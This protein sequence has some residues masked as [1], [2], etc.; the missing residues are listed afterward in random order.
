MKKFMIIVL[1][2]FGV[3]QMD[4][5]PEVRPQDLG[6]NTG[7]HI[8]EA[9]PE[10]RLPTLE[11]L[12]LMNILGFETGKMKFRQGATYGKSKLMHEGADTFFGHQEIM[13]TLPRKPFGEPIKNRID[14]I[15]RTL[16]QSGYS[17]AFY[18][19]KHE[20]LLIVENALT[21]ADNVECDPG[22]AFNVTAA[23][24]TI[25][26][27]EV[28]K[29]GKL[30]RS[31][32]IV[33]RVITF[34]G[35]GVTID[36]ILSA[37]EEHDGG[38]IGVNAPK[39]GVYNRDYHCIHLGYGVDPEVQIPTI[40]GRAGFPVCLLGKAADVIQN[41]FGKSFSIVETSQVLSRMIEVAKEMDTG[42]ICCNVQETDLAGHQQNVEKYASILQTADALIGK[43][44]ETMQ[45][46][47]LLLVMADHGNDPTIGHPH[48]TRECVPLMIC[49]SEVR[50]CNLGVRSTLSDAGATAAE[51]FGVS[52]P[53]NGRSFLKEITA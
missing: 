21:V 28:L 24:D 52:A 26:F 11:R 46:E 22:Q 4:D 17:T 34:G 18:H 5:V 42:F 29:I 39:S 43:L 15:D 47:D 12:G 19:G 48:H 20:R 51:Y 23:I 25:P 30:V 10:L 35:R 31:V 49:G 8:L 27:D 41:P 1:D 33:P 9:L 3:G 2:G 45:P 53:E 40:L 6:A 50:P 14:L 38:Y 13:G 32:S 7:R 44:M 16:R 37:V 36:D